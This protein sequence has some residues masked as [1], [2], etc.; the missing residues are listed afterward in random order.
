VNRG[1][2]ARLKPGLYVLIPFELGRER[3]YAGTP[4]VVAREIMNGEDCYLSHATAW[5]NHE[6][7]LPKTGGSR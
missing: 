7:P 3:Q 1:L 2:V 4:F 5:R 6:G